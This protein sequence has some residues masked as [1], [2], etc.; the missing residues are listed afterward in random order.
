MVLKE[1]VLEVSKDFAPCQCGSK[2]KYSVGT[3]KQKM[4]NHFI[5][6]HNVPHFYCA[7]CGSIGY[8]SSTKLTPVLRYAVFKNMKEIDYNA[9]S[10]FHS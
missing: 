10:Q 2:A 9:F 5:S 1:R 4:G 7:S 8:D 3:V 6:I